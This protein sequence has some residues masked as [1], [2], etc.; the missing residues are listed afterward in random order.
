MGSSITT[1]LVLVG[2]L[3]LNLVAAQNDTS[4]V[5]SSFD[6]MK[7]SHLKC[8]GD[9]ST[10][11]QGP[12]NLTAVTT[13]S[14][15]HALYTPGIRFLDPATSKTSSFSTN[16][17]FSIQRVNS[18]SQAAGEGL[19]FVILSNPNFTGSGGGFLGV[20]G[21]D[22]R[23]GAPTL[24]VEFD[25]FKDVKTGNFTFNDINNNHVGLDLDSINSKAQVDAAPAGVILYKASSVT[26]W[27]EYSAPTDV[28]HPVRFVP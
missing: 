27:V 10:S 28:Q 15:G 2:L 20:Y 14:V 21:S 24:A 4:F 23:A 12:L 5:F 26:A 6:C 13:G 16:F 18:G 11:G 9:S 22:G 1:L 7:D 8:S 19:A 17:T 3:F 25:T